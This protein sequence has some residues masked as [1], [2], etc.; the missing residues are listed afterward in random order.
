MIV[1]NEKELGPDIEMIHCTRWTPQAWKMFADKGGQVSIA[2]L[3]EMQMRHGMPPIQAALDHGILPSISVDVETNMTADL[4]SNMRSIFTTQRALVNDRAIDGEKNVPQPVT[5]RQVIEM[6][7][8][9]GAKC[10]HLDH[11]VGS[12]TPGKYADFVILDRDI[13]HVP[14]TEMLGT[15]VIS[16]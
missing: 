6:A 3:I 10:A 9:A 14:D 11:K 16:T 5:C 8:V 2:G 15:R 7:T 12:L 13:M 1:A 4:F